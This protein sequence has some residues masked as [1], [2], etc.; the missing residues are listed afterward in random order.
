MTN[1]NWS[2][3]LPKKDYEQ[4]LVC[5]VLFDC[6][7]APTYQIYPFRDGK[8][9]CESKIVPH[10]HSWAEIPSPVSPLTNLA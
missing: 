2:S 6:I 10:I 1:L 4:L 8:W 9:Q 3:E 7:E 5:I